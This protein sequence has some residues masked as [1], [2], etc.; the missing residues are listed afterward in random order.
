[1]IIKCIFYTIFKGTYGQQ[2]TFQKYYIKQLHRPKH[3]VPVC[4]KFTKSNPNEC[5][6]EDGNDNEPCLN[7]Y[8]CSNKLYCTDMF[9]DEESKTKLSPN[10]TIVCVNVSTQLQILDFHLAFT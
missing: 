5:E 2:Q 6:D 8:S 4:E 10:S 1:M 3:P 9:T 7:F